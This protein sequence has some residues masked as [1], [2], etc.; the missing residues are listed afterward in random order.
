MKRLKFFLSIVWREWNP[1]ILDDGTEKKTYI[2]W[3]A[4]WEVAKIV[5]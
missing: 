5:H 2:G 3:S 1:E 4:A